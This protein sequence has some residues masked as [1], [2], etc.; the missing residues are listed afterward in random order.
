MASAQ[1]VAL[2]RV[3]LP[4]LAAELR[5]HEEV[6]SIS[7]AALP[8]AQRWAQVAS[9]Q[10]AW[11]LWLEPGSVCCEGWLIS[12]AVLPPPARA[13]V[14]WASIPWPEEELRVSL[15]AKEWLTSDAVPRVAELQAWVLSLGQASARRR[16]AWVL[17]RV[18]A[19]SL[20]E[21][22]FFSVRT[23]AAQ[24]EQPT[25]LQLQPVF[26]RRLRA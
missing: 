15:C 10:M 1:T 26:G 2:R 6:S 25:P 23:W 22:E 14:P 4:W 12:D 9:I 13:L 20:A 5:E 3:W 8:S 19:L 21:G 18:A 16:R 11:N 17:P 7:G 24:A